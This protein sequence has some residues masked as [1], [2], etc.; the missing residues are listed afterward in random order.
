MFGQPTE[1]SVGDD[2]FDP[3]TSRHHSCFTTKSWSSMTTGKA[4][5][6]N[7]E[8]AEWPCSPQ[9]LWKWPGADGSAGKT[10]TTTAGA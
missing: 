9:W 4:P 2:H 8:A 5:K 6:L 1:P 10:T 3:Q 7:R